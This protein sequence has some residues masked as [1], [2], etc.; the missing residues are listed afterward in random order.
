ML[1]IYLIKLVTL[2]N[3]RDLQLSSY[4]QKGQKAEQHR[5]A[6]TIFRNEHFPIHTC[7]F[8]QIIHLQRVSL[9]KETV[10]F[11]KAV[12]T[13]DVCVCVFINITVT[14]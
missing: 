6:I 13:L 7:F 2:L 1:L 14:V 8:L 9:K 4:V 12:F 3:V 5:S 10:I 11:Y